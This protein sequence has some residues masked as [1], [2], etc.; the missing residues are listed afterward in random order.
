ML[1]AGIRV[2]QLHSPQQLNCLSGCHFYPCMRSARRTLHT[3]SATAS[4]S[5]WP[6]ATR[7]AGGNL[8]SAWTPAASSVTLSVGLQS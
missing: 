7:T 6:T 2:S 8:G 1:F 3:V 5:A 4:R